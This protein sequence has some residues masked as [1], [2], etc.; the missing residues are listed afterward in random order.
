MRMKKILVFTLIV[1]LMFGQN[2]YA[3][4]GEKYN[5]LLV[6]SVFENDEEGIETDTDSATIIIEETI[7]ETEGEIE[8]AENEDTNNGEVE[9]TDENESLAEPENVIQ[10]TEEPEEVQQTIEETD[11]TS[12]CN[13]IIGFEEWKNG[14]KKFNFSKEDKPSLEELIGYFPKTMKAVLKNKAEIVDID[15]TWYC[16]GED[17][18]TS[19]AYYFQFS[20]KWDTEKYQ[21][22]E[23]LN[24][25]TDAPYVA[26]FLGKDAGITT[27]S[28][29]NSSNE[30]TIYNF[31]VNDMNLNTAAACGMLANIYHESGF[32]PN[33]TGDGGT[34]YGICQ[35]HD[36]RWIAMKNWCNSNGYDWTSLNGQLH[37]LKLFV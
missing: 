35:W 8:K 3:Q 28:V 11:Q 34:S 14:N 2:V 18:E 32:N 22:D 25:L 6:E 15:V 30:T 33:A 17:Y 21:L 7:I 24:I 1:S 37:Y 9:L 4:E 16:E 19:D 31:L 10:D 13:I 5:E 20:P 23:S 29:T 12:D 26:V 36:S 27:F